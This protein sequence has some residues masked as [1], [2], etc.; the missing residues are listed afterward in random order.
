MSKSEEEYTIS[1]EDAIVYLA[2]DL[3]CKSCV[4]KLGT[5]EADR[6]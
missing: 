4:K 3:S 2:L 5:S 1:M 6:K